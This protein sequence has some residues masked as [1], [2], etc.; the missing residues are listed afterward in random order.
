MAWLLLGII[1]WAALMYLVGPLLQKAK[2]PETDSVEIL[3]YKGEIDRLTREIEAGASPELESKKIDLQRQLLRQTEQ[4]TQ[5]DDS[6]SYLVINS[7]FA[8]FVFGAI[9][10]Y[11][12]LGRPELTAKGALQAAPNASEIQAAPPAPSNAQNQSLDSLLAQLKTKLD[13]DRKNDPAGWILYARTLMN[14]GR[15]DEAFAAYETALP[16]T[17]NDPQIV[18]EFKRA[19][20]FAAD[21]GKNSAPARG[22]TAQDVEDAASLTPEDRKEMIENMVSGLAA[23]LRESPDDP[24][25]WIRLLRARKVLGQT[26]QAATDIAVINETYIDSPVIREKILS[27]TDWAER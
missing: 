12:V 14:V 1:V 16:L 3:A 6:P 18:D 22:P 13:G 24:E 23:R 25:G 27:D 5:D 11:A 4:R 2:R 20:G 17:E 21:T 15:F 19:R 8:F 10:L 26:T 9:G 7:L